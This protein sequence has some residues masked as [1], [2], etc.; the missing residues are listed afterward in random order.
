MTDSSGYYV[1]N[2]VSDAAKYAEI[3]R[4]FGD[5]AEAVL[6]RWGTLAYDYLDMNMRNNYCGTSYANNDQLFSSLKNTLT[7]PETRDSYVVPYTHDR[8]SRTFD[9]ASIRTEV[10]AAQNNYTRFRQQE[11]AR[12]RAAAAAQQPVVDPKLSDFLKRTVGNDDLAVD[13]TKKYGDKAYAVALSAVMEPGAMV[14]DLGI[15][16]DGAFSSKNLLTTLSQES[17]QI[18]NAKL[19]T[20]LDGYSERKSQRDAEREAKEAAE[21]EAREAA[22]RAARRPVLPNEPMPDI[23]SIRLN[24]DTI[25]IPENIEIKNPIK[26]LPYVQDGK[27]YD[28][29]NLPDGFVIKG[30]LDLSNRGLKELPDLSHVKVK[31][32]LLLSGNELT[33]IDGVLPEVGKN[34]DLRHNKLTSL[35]GMPEKVKGHFSCEGNQLTTLEGAP[36]K[37]EGAFDCRNN[38]LTTLEGSPQKVG[39]AYICSDNMLTSLKGVPS[40]IKSNFDCHNNQLTSLAD[41]PQSIAGDFMADDTL[42][43]NLARDMK[44]AVKIAGAKHFLSPTASSADD[45]RI[46]Q[47]FARRNK[48]EQSN[49]STLQPFSIENMMAD[50]HSYRGK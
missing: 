49:Q 14:T 31:G 12:A 26:S 7:R 20:F 9:S 19:T 24:V 28:L 17:T 41:A 32:S 33:S 38:R 29:Y 5:Q 1:K 35:K 44:N 40:E 39:G 16:V 15:K 34:I 10:V 43:A 30:D 23:S 2:A 22:E 18:D 8:Y 4:I 13:L 46:D 25:A 45:A 21:R 36:K 48:D 3:R 50:I 27:V 37:V 42:S 47:A 11:Q 6:K